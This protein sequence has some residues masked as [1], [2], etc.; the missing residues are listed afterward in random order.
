MMNESPNPFDDLASDGNLSS[1]N[2][3]QPAGLSPSQNPYRPTDG[4]PSGAD[5][6]GGGVPI[7]TPSVVEQPQHEQP[8]IPEF[9]ALASQF[10][11]AY[12]PYVYGRPE[13]TSQENSD[14]IQLQQNCGNRNTNA[15]N[16]G[17]MS[18]S[19]NPIGRHFVGSN[20]RNVWQGDA[21]DNS[22]GRTSGNGYVGNANRYNGSQQYGGP[23]VPF[24]GGP[25]TPGYQ[26]DIR[27]GIDMN[28]PI[29]NPLKGRWDPMAIVSIILLFF[30]LTFL[31]II[32][33]VISMW[34]IKK[35]HMK[36]FWAA[37]MCVVLGVIATLFQ[38]WLLAKGINVNDLM[39]QMLN[40]YAPSGTDNGGDGLVTT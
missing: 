36:G 34:R 21:P 3:V 32:T 19:G 11:P 30:P 25:G 28:D 10:P 37:A 14:D 29:Q 15:R 26:P 23:Q 24:T 6:A 17:R 1:R 4:N 27:N 18:G 5:G 7:Q 16:G 39:E 13:E 12:D 33:G 22:V 2:D 8:R 9:G 35:Y 31:P 20:D 38:I 40:Q